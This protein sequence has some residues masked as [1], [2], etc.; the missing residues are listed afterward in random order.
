MYA[1]KTVDFN[2]RYT[3]SG[4]FE[5]VKSLTYQKLLHENGYNFTQNK[6]DN[7]IISILFFEK[8]EVGI[9][10]T[11]YYVVPGDVLILLNIKDY[12]INNIGNNFKIYE[13]NY[14]KQTNN[15]LIQYKKYLVTATLT[16]TYNI[17]VDAKNNKHAIEL[18]YGIPLDHWN[19]L[20]DLNESNI[21]PIIRKS[22]WGNLTA[23][24]QSVH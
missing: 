2:E 13:F 22:S 21:R 24:E 11:T 14:K 19:H 15:D 8:N 7:I 1:Y 6:D 4:L 10:D 23:E 16:D 3:D 12:K 18:A 20:K 5:I 9:K 17:F